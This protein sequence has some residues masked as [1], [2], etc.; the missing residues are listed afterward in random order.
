MRSRAVAQI[1][2][3]EALVGDTNVFRDSL[4]VRDGLFVEPNGDLLFELCCVWVFSGSGEVVFFAH[5]AP[6]WIRLGFLGSCLASGDNTNDMTFA[7]IAMTDKQQSKR[8][9]QE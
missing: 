7:P 6:L 3:D 1:Q 9:A 4:E 5:V 8:A 2:V